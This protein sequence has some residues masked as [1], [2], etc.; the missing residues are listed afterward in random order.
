MTTDSPERRQPSTSG[1]QYSMHSGNSPHRGIPIK[2]RKN[3]HLSPAYSSHQRSCSFK[4]RGKPRGGEVDDNQPRRHSMPVQ[5]SPNLLSVSYNDLRECREEEEGFHRVRSFKTTSKGLINDGDSFKSRSTNN[6]MSTGST[7]TSDSSS[8]KE[9]PRIVLSRERFPSEA[10]DES[11]TT[12]SCTSYTSLP[13]PSYFRVLMLGANGVGKTAIT[14]QFMTSE[15]MGAYDTTIGESFVCLYYSFNIPFS[16]VLYSNS[17]LCK[18]N[19]I[20]FSLYLLV[21]LFNYLFDFLFVCVNLNNEF[22]VNE[23]ENTR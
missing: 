3:R 21:Q 13:S 10:S 14:N 22:Y 23:Y 11:S 12:P 20:Y 19:R 17:Y 4:T 5:Q 9:E 16:Y 8:S 2:I 7:V 18:C 1:M 15:Y 6:I